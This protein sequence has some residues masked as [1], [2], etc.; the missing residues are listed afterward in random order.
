MLVAVFIKLTE[1][2][3]Q[4]ITLSS[5]YSLKR[6]A[7]KGRIYVMDNSAA[8]RLR[9]VYGI[10]EEHTSNILPKYLPELN[11]VEEVFRS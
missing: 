1:K 2:I 3:D 8:H 4:Y 7:D 6:Y 10:K 9:H 5:L 11:I